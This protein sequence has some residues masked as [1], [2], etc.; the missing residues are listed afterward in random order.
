MAGALRPQAELAAL[1]RLEGILLDL[2]KERLKHDK[3][4]QSSIKAFEKGEQ[5]SF[6]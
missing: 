1:S 3:V 4:A 6:K 2:I 5:K